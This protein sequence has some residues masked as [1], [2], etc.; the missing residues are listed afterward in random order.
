MVRANQDAVEMHLR[1]SWGQQLRASGVPTARALACRSG[2]VAK[3][4]MRAPG[5]PAAVQYL[6]L[7]SPALVLARSCTGAGVL[8]ALLL[9]GCAPDL[10]DCRSFATPCAGPNNLSL[11]VQTPNGASDDPLQL[12]GDKFVALTGEVDGKADSTY[13]VVRPYTGSKD[14]DIR[15]LWGASCP[16]PPVGRGRRVRVEVWSKGPSGTPEIPI[17]RGR[18]VPFDVAEDGN[19]QALLAYVTRLNRFAPVQDA[20]GGEASVSLGR[21]G[22]SANTLPG[23]DGR[24]VIV[25]GALPSPGAKKAFDPSSYGQFSDAVTVYD[26]KTRV[27]SALSQQGPEYALHV[28]RAFHA[29]AAG[30]TAIVIAG[31]Y[32]KGGTTPQITNTIEYIDQSGKVRTSQSNS[33]DLKFARAGATAVQMFEN[34]DFFLILGGKGDTPCKDTFGEDLIC[35]GNTWELWHPIEGNM[36]Q[37]RLN[38]ARWNHAGVLIP[39]KSGSYVMLIGGENDEGVRADFEVVQFTASGGG[40]ISDKGQTCTSDSSA[41][42]DTF[43]WE[44]LVQSMPVARTLPGAAYVAVPRSSTEQVYSHVYI[45]G[46]FADKARTKAL[47]RLDVFDLRW[48]KYLNAEGYSLSTGR[49]APMVAAV[50][51]PTRQG[52]VLIAGGSASDTIHFASAE[53]IYVSVGGGQEPEISIQV[54]ISDNEMPGGG[55]ALGQA[56]ALNTGHVL[57]LGGVGATT[58]GLIGQDSAALWNPWF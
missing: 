50:Q 4:P 18:T 10:P 46:G 27:L 11:V 17:G 23:P 42:C 29:S 33:P 44:P 56:I 35:A 58:S 22:C 1:L 30:K 13:Q 31:G 49:A 37:G 26:P 20:S 47:A 21:A 48:G 19:P 39:G 54:N 32:V 15:C 9:L 7:L 8:L 52:Q 53:M 43:L 2:R 12:A 41:S 16:G 3:A 14:F 24:V 57:V 34:D 28:P 45:I 38:V 25:G 55:H 40:R 5:N 6:G 51:D 36:A